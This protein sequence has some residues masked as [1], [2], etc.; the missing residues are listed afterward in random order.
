MLRVWTGRWW[1]R[2]WWIVFLLTMVSGWPIWLLKGCNDFLSPR[3]DDLLACPWHIAS[4]SE[5]RQMFQM[6]IAKPIPAGVTHIRAAEPLQWQDW[7][8]VF[9]F[10]ATDQA[11][12]DLIEELQPVAPEDRDTFGELSYLK[13]KGSVRGMPWWDAYKL[14][15]AECYRST[16]HRTPLGREASLNVVIDRDTHTV[17]VDACVD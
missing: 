1:K 9:K 16:N 4:A 12:E 6:C 15:D 5:A 17:Y 3:L 13:L 2:Y 11:M 10:N 14:E 8:V 7:F